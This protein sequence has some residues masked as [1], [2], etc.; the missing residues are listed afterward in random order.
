MAQRLVGIANNTTQIIVSGARV[1]FDSRTTAEVTNTIDPTNRKRP[2][3]TSRNS[4][5]PADAIELS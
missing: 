2:K 5:A 4:P 3:R 1:A